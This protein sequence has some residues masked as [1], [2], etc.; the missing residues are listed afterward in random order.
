MRLYRV[1]V[2]NCT[3][4][5]SLY[6]HNIRTSPSEGRETYLKTCQIYPSYNSYNPGVIFG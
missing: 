5:K 4:H 3:M 1:V 6:K 2:E